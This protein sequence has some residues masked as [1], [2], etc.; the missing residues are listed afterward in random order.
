MDFAELEIL[1]KPEVREIIHQHK[2]TDATAFALTFKHAT[3]PV[4]LL[5]TQIK[6]LQRA[7][8]K[9][10]AF[11]DADAIIPPLS[12]E[13]A[14]SERAAAVKNFQG[15]ICVDVT[16][17]LGVDVY[18]FSSH[19]HEVIAIEANA[20]LAAIAKENM[21][22]LHLQNVNILHETAEHFIMHY[23]GKQID[24]LYVDP[25]RR[26]EIGEK[27]FL[28]SDCTP[29][30]HTFLPLTH[31]KVRNVCAKVSPLYDIAAAVKDFPD[32]TEI[33]I[34][35]VG[36]ECREVLLLWK[37]GETVSLPHISVFCFR[38]G[39]QMHFSF[40]YP[41]N[42]D[43]STTVYEGKPEWIL[44]PDVAFYKCR[45]VSPLFHT[46]FGSLKGVLN[47]AQGYFLSEDCPEGFPGFV[48]KIYAQMPYNP[49]K[50]KA[51][52]KQAA[53]KK[54]NITR[55]FFPFS[56]KQIRQTLGLAEGGEWTFIFTKNAEDAMT[57]YIC[58]PQ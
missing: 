9:M 17:G 21:C 11:Y 32:L 31:K 40:P 30:L 43:T 26:S 46:Y 3:Y 48:F 19:F 7:R 42:P 36:N 51:F 23:Q 25:A 6:Y 35:S 52:C 27:V 8:K 53:I 5:A 55:R 47:N 24:W 18:H 58:K 39:Q 2:D 16:C 44:E 10:P 34:V 33:H 12:Y 22:R 45:C 41:E 14:S 50:I 54:A 13:Q 49:K 15:D 28:L 1:K 56:T 38:N 57:V 4:A 37:A 29:N 20:V